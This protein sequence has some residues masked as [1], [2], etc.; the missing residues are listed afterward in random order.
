MINNNNQIAYQHVDVFSPEPFCGNSLSVFPDSRGLTSS[1][2]LTITQE[3][4]HFESIFLEPTSDK[5]TVRARIYDLIE[6][7]DFAGHPIIGAACVLHKRSGSL[8][9]EIWTFILNKKSVNVSTEKTPGGYRAFQNQGRPEFLDELP[10]TRFDEFASAL[11]LSINDM[12]AKY[13][14]MVV[15]TGLHYLVFPIESGIEHAGIIHPQF[16]ALLATVHAQFAYVLDVNNLEGRHWNNDGIIEDIATGSA[17]GTVGA[18]LTKH[19]RVKAN[20]E[21]ILHQGRFT[22]RPGR[23]FVRGEGSQN[24]IINVSVGGDVTWIGEGRIIIPMEKPNL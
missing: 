19:G 8:N 20:E 21:F 3:M 15:S 11:N 1:Q 17:A 18:Y 4:R 5:H 14:P 24:D 12:S 22:G 6:E 10:P 2:M 23:M 7:L 13:T 9:K 16:A